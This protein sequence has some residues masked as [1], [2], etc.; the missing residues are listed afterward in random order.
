MTQE[1]L[2]RLKEWVRAEIRLAGD[3]HSLNYREACEAEAALDEVFEDE[4]GET[5]WD[6]RG[7]EE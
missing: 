7:I 1:Q 2:E 6:D 5:S 4:L 3:S